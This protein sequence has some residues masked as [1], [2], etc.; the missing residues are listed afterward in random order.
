MT[1]VQTCALPISDLGIS[2]VYDWNGGGQTY[3]LDY[4]FE[5]TGDGVTPMYVSLYP[6]LGNGNYKTAGF[7]AVYIEGVEPTSPPDEGIPEPATLLLFGTGALGAFGY[8][9][10]RMMK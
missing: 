8:A 9:R 3:R 10:R 6:G 7:T 5:Y 4:T 2:P 1:G